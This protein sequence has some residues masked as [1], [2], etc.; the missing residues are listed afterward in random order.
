MIEFK[1]VSYRYD[2]RQPPVLERLSLRI[3]DGQ[4]V[5]IIGPN[6]CG[7]TTLSKHLNAL[8]LP[9]RGEVGVDGLNTRDPSGHR[10]LRRRVGMVFQNPDHQIV[11][12]TVAEDIAFGLE[13]LAVPPGE[14][15]IRVREALER[16]G[17]AGCGPR[18]PF[19]LSGG[20]KRLVSLAGVLAMNPRWLVL[21]EPAAYLDAAGRRR[22]LAMVASLHREGMGVVHITHDL[23]EAAAAERILVLERGRLIMDGRPDEVCAFL[24]S[25]AQR[26]I[27]P[28][29]MA[30]LM[31]RLR[32]SGWDVP[33]NVIS[34]EAAH[35]G[36]H[37]YLL[38]LARS[39]VPS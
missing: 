4:Y 18:A 8:L 24:M 22:T 9:S 21:D 5:A 36:I 25:E 30:V 3:P 15:A 27:E 32:Q 35:R 34:L 20:E 7:K 17:M 10:E 38:K 23:G 31:A 1:D 33:A 6:G 13:N 19:T 26:E 28:P 16:V 11:G 12:M 39:G 14:I 37:E 2:E 29:A